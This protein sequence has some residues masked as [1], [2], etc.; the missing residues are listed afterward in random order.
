MSHQPTLQQVRNLTLVKPAYAPTSLNGASNT[1]PEQTVSE[2]SRQM[3]LETAKEL[4]QR[5]LDVVLHAPYDDTEAVSYYLQ[6]L[7]RSLL[8]D[9]ANPTEA[10]G[11]LHDSKVAGFAVFCLYQLSPWESSKQDDFHHWS[12]A[13]KLYPEEAAF[14]LSFVREFEQWEPATP[15]DFALVIKLDRA[16]VRGARVGA[17]SLNAEAFIHWL[18]HNH[19]LVPTGAELLERAKQVIA[20]GAGEE[21][22][23]Q[24]MAI[25]RLLLRDVGRKYG[26]SGLNSVR[27]QIGSPPS[28]RRRSNLGLGA[29]FSQDVYALSEQYQRLRPA[30]REAFKSLL[31]KIDSAGQLARR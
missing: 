15:E 18:E 6:T 5:A 22:R 26:R 16:I 3:T 23:A 24:I 9:A 4:G 10:Q 19:G 2:R 7:R 17:A 20:K 27:R 31:I 14:A 1:T 25:A 28:A 8:D 21:R 12:S 29:Q 11:S 13:M 30:E